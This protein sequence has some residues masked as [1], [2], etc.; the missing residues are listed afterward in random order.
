VTTFLVPAASAGNG[1][2]VVL[3]R[4]PRRKPTREF[5]QTADYSDKEMHAAVEVDIPTYATAIVTTNEIVK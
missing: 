4:F 2:A 3:L 5:L 1:A